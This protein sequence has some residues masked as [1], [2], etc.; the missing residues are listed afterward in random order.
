MK[1]EYKMV[2]VKATGHGILSRTPTEGSI[3]RELRQQSSSGWRL[4]Q[5]LT[6]GLLIRKTWLV[7]ERPVDAPKRS[8]ESRQTN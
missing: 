1:H 6:L 5:V 3:E 2:W 4:V 8:D 7:L